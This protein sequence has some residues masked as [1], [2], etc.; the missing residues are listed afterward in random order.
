[1]FF[2]PNPWDDDC[3]D[4]L[5]RGAALVPIEQV[6]AELAKDPPD[7]RL[8]GFEGVQVGPGLVPPRRA[9]LGTC[10]TGA[11]GTG[12]SLLMMAIQISLVRQIGR[13]MRMFLFDPKKSH[14]G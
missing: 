8:P 10:I 12:K 3:T 14:L 4:R 1:M 11:P 5:V 2:P 6:Q 13:G 9:N 7:K